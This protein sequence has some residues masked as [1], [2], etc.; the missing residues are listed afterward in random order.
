MFIEENKA[1]FGVEPIRKELPIASQTY[2]AA[3]R[4]K[5]F[6]R[7][8]SHQ[9]T[10]VEI[11]RV[12]EGNYGVYGPGRSMP[13][14]SERASPSR[15]AWLNGSSAPMVRAGVAGQEP[16]QDQARTRDGPPWRSRRP[17]IHR[18]CTGPAPGRGHHLHPNVR[19]LGLRDLNQNCYRNLHQSRRGWRDSRVLPPASE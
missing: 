1:E 2:Y 4:R 13:S 9:V 16:R 7:A 6:A 18:G 5:P 17:D 10:L 12:H 3:R 15:V 8:V 14:A 11:C 19:R